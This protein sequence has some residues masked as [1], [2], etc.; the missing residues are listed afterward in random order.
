LPE[1]GDVFWKIGES[2]VVEITEKL[3][4]YALTG[5]RRR[6]VCDD[7]GDNL[8][9]VSTGRKPPASETFPEDLVDSLAV[10]GL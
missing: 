2:Q 7:D 10:E 3:D 9:L 8:T 5:S 4:L 1:P 6:D